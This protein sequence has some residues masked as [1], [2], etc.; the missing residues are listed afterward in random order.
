MRIHSLLKFNFD[1]PKACIQLQLM[2]VCARSWDSKGHSA[3]PAR[4]MPYCLTFGTFVRFLWQTLPRNWP[5]W[6]IRKDCNCLPCIITKCSDSSRTWSFR[7]LKSAQQI[8]YTSVPFSHHYNQLPFPQRPESGWLEPN[9]FKIWAWTKPGVIN[10]NRTIAHKTL[11]QCWRTQLLR[12]GKLSHASFHK[13]TAPQL[14]VAL[15]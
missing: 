13:L 3:G 1:K 12:I 10:H 8:S 14:L 5:N 6:T 15:A 2:P 4:I 11:T 9:S 7:R